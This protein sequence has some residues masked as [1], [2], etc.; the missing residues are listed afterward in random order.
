MRLLRAS[1]TAGPVDTTIAQTQPN[2][3][4]IQKAPPAKYPKCLYQ[5]PEKLNGSKFQSMGSEYNSCER[6]KI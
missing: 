6:E 1:G 2:N 4:M 5:K 3:N